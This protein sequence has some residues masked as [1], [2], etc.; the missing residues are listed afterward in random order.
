MTC[1]NMM[2][3][4]K[5]QQYFDFFRWAWMEITSF[6]LHFLPLEWLNSGWDATLPISPGLGHAGEERLHLI[7]PRLWPV[8]PV[9]CQPLRRQLLRCHVAAIVRP[10]TWDRPWLMWEVEE[11]KTGVR[12]ST[13]STPSPCYKASCECLQLCLQ[14]QRLVSMTAVSNVGPLPQTEHHSNWPPLQP[15]LVCTQCMVSSCK[16]GK[17]ASDKCVH[18]LWLSLFRSVIDSGDILLQLDPACRG[19]H[20]NTPL[21]AYD[22]CRSDDI[23]CLWNDN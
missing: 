10:Q 20:G 12:I 15:P 11:V 2:C 23:K 14:W 13:I 1:Q 5:L 7:T 4:T 3:A 18:V 22:Q 17:L 6:Y 19:N 21:W 16:S 8:T 9:C